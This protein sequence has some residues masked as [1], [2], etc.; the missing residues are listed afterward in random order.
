M[1]EIKENIETQESQEM[2]E[3][4]MP[5]VESTFEELGVSGEIL[6]AI[7]EMGYETPMPVQEKVIPYLLGH[8]NDVVA[9]AQTGTGKTAAYGLP[10]L[11]KID[12]TRNEVQAVIMAPTRELC[13]QITDDLKD[14]SKYINGLHVLAVYGGASL[15]LIHI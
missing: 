10:V 14:Y 13:L 12:T 4:G 9:L 5:K 8:N 2:Q 15:S 6:R 7:R 11:Q 3:N 1:E